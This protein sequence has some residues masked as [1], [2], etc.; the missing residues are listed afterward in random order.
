MEQIAEGNKFSYNLLAKRHLHYF[1]KVA[2]TLTNCQDDAEDALQK[3]FTNLWV[4]AKHWNSSKNTKFTT[5]FYRIIYNAC[6]DVNRSNKVKEYESEYEQL[7][8]SSI[9]E[10]K[11]EENMIKRALDKLPAKQKQAITLCYINENP[12][13]QVAEMMGVNIKALESLLTRGK[14]KM[15]RII[16]GDIT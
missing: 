16:E 1:F 4:N 13:K 12:Q 9:I 8:T 3:A 10:K 14:Q 15:R 5:W 6:M 11:Q 7:T 2:Y